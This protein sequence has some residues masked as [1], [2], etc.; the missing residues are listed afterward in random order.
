MRS[1]NFYKCVIVYGKGSDGFCY[2]LK[3]DTAE[4]LVTIDCDVY[5][6]NPIDCQRN[7]I[8]FCQAN[9]FEYQEDWSNI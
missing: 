7:A 6:D 4:F 1:L 9:E 5:F 8:E 2:E 3:F